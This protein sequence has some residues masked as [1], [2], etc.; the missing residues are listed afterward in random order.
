MSF[1]N[2]TEFNNL[3]QEISDDELQFVDD[4]NRFCLITG[5]KLKENYITLSCNHT[6][7]YEPLYNDVRSFKSITNSLLY[8]QLK[9]PYCRTIENGI[10]P[11]FKVGNVKRIFGVNHPIQYSIMLKYCE[12]ILKS[13]KRKGE[14]CG[15]MCNN[16]SCVYHQKTKK[17]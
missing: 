8:T 13:G 17:T 9:C 4:D 11:Y 16:V 12:N 2:C 14:K 1:M 6:F 10:L 7:N 15:R 5:E 3:L